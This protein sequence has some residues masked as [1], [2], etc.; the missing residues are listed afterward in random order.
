[1]KMVDLGAQMESMGGSHV[2][3]DEIAKVVHSEQFI[4]GIVVEELEER[5]ADFT[6]R[7]H[8]IGCASG[9][10]ALLLALLALEVSGGVVLVPAFGFPAAVEMAILAGARVAFVDVNP[11]DGMMDPWS[12][13]RVLQSVD[14]E[15]MAIVVMDLFGV[16]ARYEKIVPIADEFHVPLI[17]DAA[18][19]LG[20]KLTGVRASRFCDIMTTSFFPSKPL[21]CFGD[22]GMVFTDELDLARKMT[23]LRNHGMKTKYRYES[24]GMNSR[25]DALQA[26][27]L[28]KKLEIFST[29]LVQR[30]L[31]AR[32]LTTMLEERTDL[33]VTPMVPRD[34][35]RSTWACYSVTSSARNFYTSNLERAEIPFAIH[36]PTALSDVTAYEPH[37]FSGTARFH[38]PVAHRLAKTIFQL[39]FHPYLTPGDLGKIVDA[40]STT[41]STD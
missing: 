32:L 19:S 25:L 15:T 1:M 14:E 35:V 16:P 23:L 12:L 21:G 10:D 36:Y 9:T 22:G 6:G 5:L 30:D 11:S 18:Q 37:I 20:A 29:E 8:A 17:S 39:P 4:G 38:Y 41:S 34:G 27:V 2:I 24:V 26:A 31:V 40:L 3:L 13:R 7:K 28:L 33:A